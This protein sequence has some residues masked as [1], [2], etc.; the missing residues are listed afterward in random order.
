MTLTRARGGAISRAGALRTARWLDGGAVLLPDC[1]V[2]GADLDAALGW[3]RAEP[4]AEGVLF[5][6]AGER[7]A[8]PL[9]AR[10]CEPSFRP[11]WMWRDLTPDDRHD[12]P[13]IAGLVIRVAGMSD[14]SAIAAAVGL[15]YA[16]PEVT[17]AILQMAEDPPAARSTWLLIAGIAGRGRQLA[18]LVG[19]T[20]LH[21]PAGGQQLAGIFDVGVVPA[22]RGHGV[23]EALIRTACAVARNHGARAVGLN[24]TPDG[25]RLYRRLGFVSA[26]TG[27]TWVLAADR[28]PATARLPTIAFAEALAT[29]APDAVARLAT[30]DLLRAPLLNGD[31][32]LAF[33]ARCGQPAIGRWLLARGAVPEILPLWALGLRDE[34]RTAMAEAGLRE[35]RLGADRA[36]PLHEAVRRNDPALVRALIA[37][38]ADASATDATWHS[39]PAGWARALGHDDLLPLLSPGAPI[40]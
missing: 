10:G 14:R 16:H 12:G 24:A 17:T 11:H 29:G 37:A 33:A 38:G 3:F 27:Q 9:L 34:A 39:T 35:A 4:P 31:S 32:P 21:L 1:P 5:W 26:G 30:P 28:L 19:Q 18:R 25:E 22:A 40:S 13:E 15:P 6:S 7:D 23:G 2:S 36:T 8:A 20:A